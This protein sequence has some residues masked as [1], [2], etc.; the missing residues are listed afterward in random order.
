MA[1]Q[2]T[3]AEGGAERRP[4]AE[5]EDRRDHGAGAKAGTLPEGV[6]RA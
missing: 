6:Y 1:E 3:Q 4:Q 2:E 5:A